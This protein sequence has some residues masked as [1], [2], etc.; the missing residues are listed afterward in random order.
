MHHKD[1]TVQTTLPDS[2][3]NT[4]VN[5]KNNN[6]NDTDNNHCR[7]KSLLCS[8]CDC[9][10]KNITSLY[11]YP[12][13]AESKYLKPSD[14]FR[15]IRPINNDTENGLRAPVTRHA[16]HINQLS[17]ATQPAGRPRQLPSGIT[18][19]SSVRTAAGCSAADCS[20]AKT[21]GVSTSPRD[22]SLSSSPCPNTHTV[23]HRA[24]NSYSYINPQ[25]SV[26]LSKV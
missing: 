17:V 23:I 20:A 14:T 24:Y 2:M 9:W 16:N 8:Y 26:W 19:Q 18:W 25:P 6:R 7:A 11:V 5:E 13:T 22:L 1:I 4:G 12:P 3:Q 21:Q 15:T 10:T